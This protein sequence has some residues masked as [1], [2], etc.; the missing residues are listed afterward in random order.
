MK[1]LFLGD[2]ITGWSDL[3]KYMKFSDVI[4]CMLEAY[5]GPGKVTVQ[6]KG[7]GGNTSG[8]ALARLAVDVLAAEP[9]VVVLLIGG[10]DRGVSNPLSGDETRQ[11][12]RQIITALTQQGS[13]VLLLQYHLLPN[14]LHPQTAWKHL[15]D[16]NDIIAETAKE[17]SIPVLDMMAPMRAALATQSFET[18]VNS[19]DGVHLS[20]GGELVY[21][22][23]IFSKLRGLGWLPPA[24]HD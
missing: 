22:R 24:M 1:L 10:N 12:L 21:A 15:I 23:E 20:P 19:E 13:R 6:N 17:Y 3:A 11:N 5:C 2:S 4:D 16:N 8:Q 14:P 18:L 9:D 7:V